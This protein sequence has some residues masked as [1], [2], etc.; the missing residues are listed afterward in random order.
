VRIGTAEMQERRGKRENNGEKASR[1]L[2]PPISPSSHL[3][4]AGA[5][6]CRFSVS[7]FPA[8]RETTHGTKLRDDE[9]WKVHVR[10]RPDRSR[11]LITH[12]R[13]GEKA[14]TKARDLVSG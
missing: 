1:V 8:R 12:P 3:N 13:I 14:L 10:P 6:P 11:E 4:R 9:Q 2:S 5:V 7:R